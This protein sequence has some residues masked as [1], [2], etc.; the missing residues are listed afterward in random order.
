MTIRND[1][2][3]RFLKGWM[4]GTLNTFWRLILKHYQIQ[5]SENDGVK[6]FHKIRGSASSD[7]ENYI[8]EVLRNIEG[9]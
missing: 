6:L 5:P 9:P 2:C 3:V 4:W 1:L 8:L 7:F